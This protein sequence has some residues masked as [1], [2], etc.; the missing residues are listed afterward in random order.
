MSELGHDLH[1][2]FPAQVDV[3]RGLKIESEHYRTLASRH[4]ALALENG[5]IESGAQACSDAYL[6]NL[7]KQRLH[8]LDEIAEM[9]AERQAA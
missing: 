7:K 5:R 6:E 4:H 3:L 9:M 1:A 8:L 2:L